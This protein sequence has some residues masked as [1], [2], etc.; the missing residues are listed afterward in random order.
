MSSRE[1]GDLVGFAKISAKF[2]EVMRRSSKSFEAFLERSDVRGNQQAK[3]L[4]MHLAAVCMDM[5]IAPDGR[6]V[7]HAREA[8]RTL[9][10]DLAR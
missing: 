9:C 10:E 2:S 5:G 6:V 3:L 4:V 1:L 7:V 8:V